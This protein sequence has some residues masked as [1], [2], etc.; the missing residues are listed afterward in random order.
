[1]E[2]SVLLDQRL[3][4]NSLL[5]RSVECILFVLQLRL[6]PAQDLEIARLLGRQRAFV[7]SLELSYL[8]LSLI[9]I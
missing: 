7:L 3:E 5:L 1:M 8:R 9:H 2:A 6:Q 4:V